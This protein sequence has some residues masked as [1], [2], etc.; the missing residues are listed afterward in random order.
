MHF[1][2]GSTA[3]QTDTHMHAR[4]KKKKKKNSSECL[5]GREV[6]SLVLRSTGR[7]SV[8]KTPRTRDPLLG[9]GGNS[10]KPRS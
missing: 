4:K 9:A 8:R 2:L 10:D 1:A 3:M 6:S 7:P 5:G